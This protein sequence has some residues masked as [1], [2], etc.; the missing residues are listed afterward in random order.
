MHLNHFFHL[1]TVLFF[2]RDISCPSSLAHNT[3]YLLKKTGVDVLSL[4]APFL[5]LLIHS[6]VLF[7]SGDPQGSL[8][9]LL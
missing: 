1:L 3:L 4:N 6:L 8:I 7:L 5:Y 9:D 2:H